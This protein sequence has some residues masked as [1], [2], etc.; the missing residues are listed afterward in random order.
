M[1]TIHTSKEEVLNEYPELIK[2]WFEVANT[3]GKKIDEDSNIEFYYSYGSFVPKNTDYED[4]EYLEKYEET[5]TLLYSDRLDFEIS[6]IR[7]HLG[8]KFNN[9]YISDRMTGE[10]PNKIKEI[11][12]ELT[13]VKM[14]VECDH[15]DNEEVKDSIPALN[16]DLIDVIM[17]DE[18]LGD[19]EII[20]EEN[21]D[22]D[23]IL[24]KISDSGFGSL[25]ESEKEFL[26][27]KSKDI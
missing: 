10:V 6:K 15:F 26:N 8:M 16:K 5:L 21:L 17:V 7:V 14:M 27:K 11:V 23:T 24:D 18:V 19:D 9:F 3:L 12:G 2:K 22:T 4:A 1:F 25:S 20:A 13:K